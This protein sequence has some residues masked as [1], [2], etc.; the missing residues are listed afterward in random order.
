MVSVMRG[1]R[2]NSMKTHPAMLSDEAV[3]G[4]LKPGYRIQVRSAHAAPTQG[5]ER[6]ALV[7]QFEI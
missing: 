7:T 2:A 5:V 3:A 1:C 6:F 4:I